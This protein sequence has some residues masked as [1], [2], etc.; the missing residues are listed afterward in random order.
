ME[1]KKKSVKIPHTFVLLF[2]LV[3]ICAIATWII[4]AGTYDYVVDE[5]TGR[6]VV[7][8]DSF[9]FVEGQGVGPF[10]MMLEFIKGM[11]DSSDIIFLI[12]IVGGSFMILQDT[13]VY[14]RQPH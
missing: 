13:D 5:N 3:I 11:E 14:K 2:V 12:F 7:D 8:T 4:P 6:E 10:D 9:H 1:K